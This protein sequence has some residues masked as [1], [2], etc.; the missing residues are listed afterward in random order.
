MQFGFHC[1]DIGLHLIPTLI[2]LQIGNQYITIYSTIIAYL[3]SRLW[4][5]AVTT[6]HWKVDWKVFK[7]KFC[8]CITKH[9]QK[10]TCYV[11]NG[12]VNLI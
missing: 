6:I 9:Q 5:Y 3:L 2:L 12:V 10:R 11:D 7:S 1:T 8:L 4:S